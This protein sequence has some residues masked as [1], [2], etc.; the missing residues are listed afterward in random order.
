MEEGRRAQCERNRERG[1]AASAGSEPRE[2][3]PKAK[4]TNAQTVPFFRGEW[5]S[6]ILV[7]LLV[8]PLRNFT[9]TIGVVSGHEHDDES[10][11][12]DHG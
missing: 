9:L 3:D 12:E 5:R 8:L 1:T 11:N 2:W 10:E 7:R 4:S 6:S